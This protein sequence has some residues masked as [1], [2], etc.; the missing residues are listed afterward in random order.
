MAHA[1]VLNSDNIAQR[2]AAV[3]ARF[4]ANGVNASEWARRKG[5]PVKLV[6]AVLSGKRPCRRGESHRIAVALGIK[7]APMPEA[8]E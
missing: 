3:R 1:E 5:L 2:A 7:D 6:H 4:S 8:A